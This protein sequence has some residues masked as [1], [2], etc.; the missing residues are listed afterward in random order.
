MPKA[1]GVLAAWEEGGMNFCSSWVTQDWKFRK[2]P[3]PGRGKGKPYERAGI[4]SRLSG[5]HTR[6]DRQARGVQTN[7][8]YRQYS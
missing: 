2:W 8:W 1:Y 5:R 4:G 6:K 3:E 7:G